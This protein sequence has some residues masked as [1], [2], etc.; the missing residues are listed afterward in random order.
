MGKWKQ[1]H[2]CYTEAEGELHTGDY[3]VIPYKFGCW[4]MLGDGIQLNF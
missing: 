2:G 3:H 1:Y 4:N